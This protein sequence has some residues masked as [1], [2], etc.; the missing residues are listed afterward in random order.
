MTGFPAEAFDVVVIGAG[1]AGIEAAL[2]A[3]RLGMN[4]ACFTINLDAVGNMPCNP[5]IGGTA[6]GHLVREIDALGGEMARAADAA[7]IQYRMLN[8]GKGPAVHSLRAQADRVK[9]R[10]YMKHALEQQENLRLMQDEIVSIETENGAVSAVVTAIGARHPAKAVIVA[11]G[12]FLGGRVIIGDYMRES[13][14]DGLAA[15]KPLTDSLRGLGLRLQRFKTGTPPRIHRRSIDFS[16]LEVQQ[17]EE[18]IIPFSFDTDRPP[19][20]QAVCYLTYTTGETHEVIRENLD[21]SPLY[22]GKIKG[23]GPRYCPSI[24]DKVVRFADKP[25]HQLFLEPMGLD[26]E[27]IYVQGFSSSMPFDVQLKM[28]HTV[29]GMEHAEVMRPAYAIEYD[30][31]DP[32]ELR[33][34]LE[35]KKIKGLYGAGQFCGSS[36]YEEAAAQGL[37]AGVNA[38]LQLKGE[39]PLILDR[40]DGYIGT[41]IDDLVTRGTN[42]PYRM[43][44]SRSEYRLLLRQDNADERLVPIGVRI[45][46]NPPERGEK[47]R[48][49]YEAVQQEIDRVA[50]VGIAP[51][52]A[53]NGFLAGK[54]SAPVKAGCKLIDLLRRPELSY[55]D[56]ARFDPDRPALPA[57]IREQVEIRIKYAGYISR[58]EKDVEQY[59]KLQSRPLPPALD[60]NSIDSIRLEA[61]QKLNAVKPINFGQAARISGVSPADITALMIY[62]ETR[63]KEDKA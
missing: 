62:M 4:T 56:L 8:R 12:T 59:R 47:V 48:R 20:N 31:V 24:E 1:H 42:E 17:G 36:G 58:Q 52:D 54:N 28:L 33:P 18:E 63:W 6:K 35:T 61:R 14:P 11:S 46:L 3:A 39:E 60:Y 21:R 40:A 45:G 34:T 22:G 49:K 23:V 5:A 7:C 57:V 25:R 38:A 37:V 44:T 2:A 13:G 50:S 29:K 53:L 27:E 41:L 9:Y 19:C 16:G 10:S 43:M 26:T 30:C 32:L 15:A 55:A 51:S